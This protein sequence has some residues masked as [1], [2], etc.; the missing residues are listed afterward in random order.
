MINSVEKLA[1]YLNLDINSLSYSSKAGKEFSFTVPMSFV[2]RMKKS[3]PNDPLLLQILPQEKELTQ[4]V[5]FS[6]DP[7]DEKNSI[8][9][10]GLL[11]K[12]K[13][14]VLLIVT[15]ACGIH[16]RYCFR[17]HYPYAE[18]VNNFKQLDDN[19]QLIESNT[20]ITEVILSGGDPL[21]LS[22]QRIEKLLEKLSKIKHLKRLRIHTRQIIVEPK[23][24]TK[25]LVKTLQNFPLPVALVV[26]INH[27][28]EINQ[29]VID[30][31]T[32]LKNSNVQ[33]LNQSVLLKNINNN[34]NTLIELSEKLFESGILPYYLHLL[35]E[36]NGSEHYN[37]LIDDAKEI[38]EQMKIYL[39][40][41]LVPKLVKEYSNAMYKQEINTN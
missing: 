5:G 11:Q 2:K 3:D 36:V 27:P 28:A 12:Y 24:I 4:S 21:T 34:S 33:L 20:E 14:R 30:S 31:L 9:A 39:P 25:S 40:G 10:P 35:D 22:D 29:E 32:P 6:D 1:Q 18:E 26:H 8:L 37:V 41:Y 38:I 13:H 16:C 15:P 17:R 7:L 19:I 23:R